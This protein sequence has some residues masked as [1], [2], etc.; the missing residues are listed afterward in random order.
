MI[1]EIQRA[2]ELLNGVPFKKEY[3][4]TAYCILIKYY[5]GLGLRPH[6]AKS[7]IVKWENKYGYNRYFELDDVIIKFYDD[8]IKARGMIV[9]NI[10][11][12]DIL[13]IKTRFDNQNQRKIAFAL[14]CYAKANADKNGCFYMSYS[15]L[16]NWISMDIDN[17]K[18][19]HFN[20]IIKFDYIEKTKTSKKT[21]TWDKEKNKNYYQKNKF[22][23]NVDYSNDFTGKWILTD[24]NIL[25]LF[26]EIFI[27][28]K[29]VDSKIIIEND[30]YIM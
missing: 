18:K 5:L 13:E 26:E 25:N 17:M 29:L 30:N 8:N 2:E 10:S 12:E 20:K 7:N 19:R 22:K 27:G 14:L 4:F 11:D 24:N 15:E 6:E 16:A 3:F 23:I 1:N 21:F 28:Y 9:V